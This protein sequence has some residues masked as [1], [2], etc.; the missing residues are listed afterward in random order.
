MASALGAKDQVV[1][2][3]KILL[4]YGSITILVVMFCPML[5]CKASFFTRP[6]TEMAATEKK[7]ATGRIRTH[8]LE[9]LPPMLDRS[10]LKFLWQVFRFSRGVFTQSI[11]CLKWTLE[12]IKWA[13]KQVFQPSTIR[14]RMIKILESWVFKNMKNFKMLVSSGFFS[15]FICRTRLSHLLQ[16]LRHYKL[17]FWKGDACLFR[18]SATVQVFSLWKE[19][20]HCFAGFDD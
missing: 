13:V 5:L 9:V 19:E 1:N 7:S 20:L 6:K 8:D 14:L 10:S 4:H 18:G 15:V 3:K 11:F 12:W 17:Y 2:K 16:H